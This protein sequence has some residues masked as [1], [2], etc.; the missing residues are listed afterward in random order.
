VTSRTGLICLAMK[1]ID[2]DK[3]AVKKRFAF[4]DGL[5]GLFLPKQQKSLSGSGG[6]RILS[7]SDLTSVSEE[8]RQAIEGLK[9]GQDSSG[10]VLLVIDQVDLLLA[11]GGNQVTA[12]G[13]GEMLMGLREVRD[14]FPFREERG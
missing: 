7:K 14:H 3:L 11:A 6:E 13:L 5:S 2:F 8:I 10:R 4:V 12:I 1:G 9:G